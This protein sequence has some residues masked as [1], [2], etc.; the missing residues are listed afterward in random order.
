VL[1]RSR[2]TPIALGGA[3]LASS[4]LILWQGRG[5]TFGGDD[6]FYFARLVQQ[7]GAVNQESFGLEYLLAPHNGH[8][9]L[10]GKLIYEGLFATVGADYAVFRLVALAGF[11][12]CVV[13]FFLLCRPRIGEPASLLLC[14]LLLFLGGAWEVMLWPF[15]LHTSLAV[16][17]GLGALLALERDGPRAD[18]ACCLLLIASVL[19]IEVGLA[20]LGGVAVSVLLREDRWQRL[21]IVG[22]PATLYLAWA[23]WAEGFGQSDLVF[24]NLSHAAPS[25][26]SSLAATVGS[27]TGQIEHGEGV[28][29]GLASTTE[30]APV[31]AVIVAALIV[32]RLGRGDVQPSTWVFLATLLIYWG[33]IAL[34]NRAPD[35]SRYIFPG[36]LL[37]LLL[38]AD[39]VRGR[40]FGRGLL[41]GIAVVIAI[42]LP[43]NVLKLGDGR[44]AQVTDAD[45][46]G[47]E[48]AMIELAR[49]QVAA[50]YLA[51][52]DPQVLETAPVPH[53]GLRAADYLA[54]AD[55][56]G[57]IAFSLPELRAAPPLVR[58]GADATLVGA[59]GIALR[60]T[61]AGS[62]D[63]CERPAFDGSS[64]RFELPPGGAVIE[65][66]GA[67]PVRIGLGRFQVAPPGVAVGS[68]DGSAA[69][70][71]VVPPDDAP[72][73][74][75]AFA[76]SPVAVCPLDA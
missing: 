40:R 15:D 38:G 58:A 9:Q 14:I 36:A 29:A 71:L 48:Y 28:F 1:T 59:L 13:L 3:I 69:A 31:V 75:V 65:A 11:L 39:L 66:L 41:I 73:P 16:A 26:A 46:S 6:L 35:S 7:D 67:G 8:L 2:A 50:D 63:A 37:L 32:W 52:A 24:T 72:D 47:A 4:V 25:V 57:S 61:Q 53:I 27:L 12:A 5:T 49:G 51:S 43:A 55:R 34:A 60:P 44:D 42:A 68:I 33:F 22:A 70:E 17:A 19:T 21:W 23:A 30:A 62:G 20:F 76:D 64:A 56:I 45:A 10:V 54:A 18:L 74:W